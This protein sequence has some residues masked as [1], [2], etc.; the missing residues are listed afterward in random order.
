[1]AKYSKENLNFLLGLMGVG[2]HHPTMDA[3][4]SKVPKSA[5]ALRPGDFIIFGYKQTPNT[6][7]RQR[8]NTKLRVAL[9][10]SN[11]RTGKKSSVW[12]NVNTANNLLSCFKLNDSSVSVTDMIMQTLYKTGPLANYHMPSLQKLFG[13]DNYRTYKLS[14]ITDMYEINLP[15]GERK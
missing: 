11:W 7:S 14:Q 4:L 8:A 9:L 15:L 1:M 10:V 2:H 3:R 13:K 6:P 5:A 12:G